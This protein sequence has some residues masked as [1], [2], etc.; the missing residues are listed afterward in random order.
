MEPLKLN[1]NHPGFKNGAASLL[2]SCYK[3]P[4]GTCRFQQLPAALQMVNT[5]ALSASRRG[6]DPSP[7]TASQVQKLALAYKSHLVCPTESSSQSPAAL[8]FK[9][10][11]SVFFRFS[12]NF[13]ILLSLQWRQSATQIQWKEGQWFVQLN[14]WQRALIWGESFDGLNRGDRRCQTQHCCTEALSYV[15]DAVTEQIYLYGCLFYKRVNS[16]L[17]DTIVL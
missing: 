10:I 7:D 9:I 16:F 8:G 1:T 12:A 17:T 4:S 6:P 3:P 2:F 15:N 13:Y 14:R 11:I 5:H